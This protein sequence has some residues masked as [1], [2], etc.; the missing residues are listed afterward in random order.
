MDIGLVGLGSMG[1]NLAKNLISKNFKV[2]A[3]EKNNKILFLSSNNYSL[4]FLKYN[5]LF[6]CSALL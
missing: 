2:N 1:L 6:F 3:F 5:Y 4:S